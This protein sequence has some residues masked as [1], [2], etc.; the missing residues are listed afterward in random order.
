MA[1]KD[2]ILGLTFDLEK[3]ETMLGPIGHKYYVHRLKF[4]IENAETIV[5]LLGHNGLRSYILS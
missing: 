2:Y 1:H 3:S 5:G 4:E